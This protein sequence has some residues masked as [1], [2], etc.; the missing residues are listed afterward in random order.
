MNTPKL[1]L[2]RLLM[3]CA[4]KMMQRHCVHMNDVNAKHLKHQ[5]P[6]KL[7]AYSPTMGIKRKQAIGVTCE[8]VSDNFDDLQPSAHY[9]MMSRVAC[10]RSG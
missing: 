8:K 1:F 7:F 9:P 5:K 6:A 10:W 3:L 2:P 4:L